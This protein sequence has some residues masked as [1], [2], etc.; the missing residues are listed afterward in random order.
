MVPLRSHGKYGV[1][2]LQ[3]KVQVVQHLAPLQEKVQAIQ[4]WPIP[5][6]IKALQGL[7]GLLGFYRRFMRGYATIIVLL[8]QLLAKD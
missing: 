2:P 8:T 7:L 1:E 6:S 5:C 4:Q 3:E